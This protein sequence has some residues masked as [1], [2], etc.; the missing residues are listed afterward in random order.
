MTKDKKIRKA[1]ESLEKQREMHLKKI[2]DEKKNYVLKDYWKKE[3]GIFER[4]IEKKK[5]KLKP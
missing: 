3:I 5:K 1:I 2:E 4:E